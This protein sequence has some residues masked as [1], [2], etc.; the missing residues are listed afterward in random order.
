LL[1]K[2]HIHKDFIKKIKNKSNSKSNKNNYYHQLPINIKNLNNKSNNLVESLSI[3]LVKPKF[4]INH[5][6][7]N[8]IPSNLSKKY[9]KMLSPN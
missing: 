3:K 7:N 8:N 9:P 6:K 2:Y 5:T 4:I 1:I